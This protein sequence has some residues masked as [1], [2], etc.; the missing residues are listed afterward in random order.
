MTKAEFGT[1]FAAGTVTYAFAFILNGPLTD[2]IGGRRAMLISAIG[3]AVSNLLVGL[4]LRGIL[5]SR[6]A[7]LGLPSSSASSTPSTCTSR[8][9]AR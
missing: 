7:A 6:R 4:V 8:A 1:I 2:R 5:F 3:A 9:S